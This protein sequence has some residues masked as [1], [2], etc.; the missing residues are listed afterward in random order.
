MPLFTAI[1]TPSRHPLNVRYPLCILHFVMCELRAQV[2]EHERIH[3]QTFDVGRAETPESHGG[4]EWFRCWRWASRV[5]PLLRRCFVD[6]E[7]GAFSFAPS[8]L[9]SRWVI[10]IQ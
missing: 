10:P 3:S 6:G 8:A 1:P 9:R 5:V 2:F 7:G 4:V